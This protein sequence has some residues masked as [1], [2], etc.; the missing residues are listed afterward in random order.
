MRYYFLA[1]ATLVAVCVGCQS[2][3]PG[4]LAGRRSQ[5]LD[6]GADF[7]A[8]GNYDS[9]HHQNYTAPPASMMLRPGPGVDGPGPGVLNPIG[10]ASA[11]AIGQQVTQVKFLEPEGMSIGW[12]I[13]GGYANNQ[14]TA[15]MAAFNFM[16][17][18]SYRLKFTNIPGRDGLV[19]YP[20][21]QVYPTHPQTA[22][23]LSHNTV[24]V[25]LTDEDLDQI[26]ANNFVTKVIYLPSPQHQ[27][28]A[29]AGVETLVSTRLDP[30]LDPVAEADRR[31]T[32]LA[33]IRAGNMNM[34]TA[35]MRGVVGP[36]G[37]IKQ[38]SHIR[39]VDGES[40][41]FVAP[42]PIEGFGARGHG[43]PP[44]LMMGVQGAPG[45]PAFNPVTGGPAPSWGM[46]ITGT[47]IGLPGP[48][49]MPY[50]GK[51]GLKSH[52]VRN[53]TKQHIPEPVDHFVLDVKHKP[54]IRLPD[55]V[56]HVEYEEKHFVPVNP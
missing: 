10:M 38:A 31:G 13:P 32:I 42:M 28:L 25:Q 55:P 11:G 23:F 44:A 24:P 48:P 8:R 56:K 49:H 53:K 40:G 37:T 54:G 15:G 12:Q 3:G 14:L 29:I 20:T 43:I 30:G 41:Q 47:P 50:G 34:E 16:Q 26:Q 46:P 2:A 1:L 36:D 19:L 35:D 45:M 9:G 18:A 39:Q 51:A 5:V 52:T 4:G 22:A 21:L 27:E 17:G 6:E 33:V 7:V